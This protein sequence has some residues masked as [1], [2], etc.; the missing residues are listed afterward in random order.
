MIDETSRGGLKNKA[1][2]EFKELLGVFLYLAFFFSAIST[3]RILLLSEFRDWYLSYSFSV[4]NAFVIAKVILIGEYTHLGRKYEAKPLLLSSIYKAFLFCL[5]ALCFHFV[6]EAIKRLL[7]GES[8]AGIP[9]L[10][11]VDILLARTLIVFCTFIPF[12][13][14]R[15]LRRVLGEDK[16]SDLFFRSRTEFDLSRREVNQ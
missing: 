6:E 7:H 13:A 9:H 5:L 4:I 2:H 12:F 3:Y 1:V 14:F 10:I 11:H 8:L 15:E 16:F